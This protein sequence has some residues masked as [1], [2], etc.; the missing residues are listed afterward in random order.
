MKAV[1]P[2]PWPLLLSRLRLSRR[3]VI[4]RA[5]FDEAGLDAERLLADR[6]IDRLDGGYWQPPDCEQACMPNLDFESQRDA[7]V[8]GVACPYEPACWPGWQWLPR[9]ALENY[10]CPADRVFSSLRYQNGLEPLEVYL[11][12]T[13]V[14]VGILARRGRHVPVVWMARPAPAFDAVCQGLAHQLKGDG[15]IVLLSHVGGQLLDVRRQGDVVVLQLPEAA[16]GDFSLWRALDAL[17][18]NYR[19]TR[20]D[21]PAGVFE[22]VTLEFATIP[23]ERHVVHINGHDCGGFRVSDLKFLR[24]LL[25]AAARAVEADVDTGGWI[26]KWRLRGDDKDHDIEALRKDLTSHPVEGLS[27]AEMKGLIKSSPHRDGRIRL[28]VDP[29]HIRFDDSLSSLRFV[30]EQQTRSRSGRKGSTPGAEQ[31]AQN[32]QKA[33]QNAGLILKNLTELGVAVPLNP[34]G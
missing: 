25:L 29:R 6:I 8:V 27:P 28:A 34:G 1:A 19:R 26:D 5:E 17:D 18:P 13:I 12:S 24:L 23:G 3:A 21:D 32:H 10:C 22:D 9:T 7:A 16:N 11:E 14:P 30:G 15:L 2:S 33:R 31:L 4:T 20:V